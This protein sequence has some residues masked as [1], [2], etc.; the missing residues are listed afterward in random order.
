M[1]ALVEIRS[2]NIRFTGERQSPRA[3]QIGVVTPGNC[4]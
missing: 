2:L 1:T 4:G 3:Q